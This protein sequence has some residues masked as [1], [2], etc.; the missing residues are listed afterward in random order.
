MANDRLD[1]MMAE[2]SKAKQSV[3]SGMG[4]WLPILGRGTPDLNGTT[5]SSE[6][7]QEVEQL[8]MEDEGQLPVGTIP[9][10]VFNQAV[11]DN[12]RRSRETGHQ[13]QVME[14]VLGSPLCDEHGNRFD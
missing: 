4:Q 1:K 3:S 11:Y 2:S 14:R 12:N 6:I 7:V 13:S 8:W 9:R 10:E 5:T